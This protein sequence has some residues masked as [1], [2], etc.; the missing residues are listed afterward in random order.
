MLSKMSREMEKKCDITGAPLAG[1]YPSQI[2]WDHLTTCTIT[3]RRM[4]WYLRTLP[5]LCKCKS[6]D[7]NA[8]LNS[9]KG[10]GIKL[11]FRSNE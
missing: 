4:S 11:P 7:W 10:R 8:C 3:Q 6:T 2:C 5:K 1:S 9:A